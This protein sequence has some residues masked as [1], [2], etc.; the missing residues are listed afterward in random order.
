MLSIC[1]ALWSSI[2]K[3]HGDVSSSAP[4]H[5]SRHE[6]EHGSARMMPCERDIQQCH[7]DQ[8]DGI[9]DVVCPVCSNPGGYYS[10]LW[11]HP[12]SDVRY[13]RHPMSGKEIPGTWHTVPVGKWNRQDWDRDEAECQQIQQEMISTPRPL[14]ML[15]PHAG[16]RFAGFVRESVFSR[17]RLNPSARPVRW[18]YYIA[19]LHLDDK[20]HAALYIVRQEDPTMPIPVSTPTMQVH[21][22]KKSLPDSI[23]REHSYTWVEPELRENFPGAKHCVLIPSH[24]GYTEELATWLAKSLY[25]SHHQNHVLIVFTADLTHNYKDQDLHLAWPQQLSKI[26]REEDLMDSLISPTRSLETFLSSARVTDAPWAMAILYRLIQLV[27]CHGQVVDYMDSKAVAYAREG[28]G[29]DERLHVADKLDFYTLTEWKREAKD[30]QKILRQQQNAQEEDRDAFVSYVGM[31]FQSSPSVPFPKTETFDDMYLLGCIRS[32]ILLIDSIKSFQDRNLDMERVIAHLVPKWSVWSHLTNGVFVG[33]EEWD[34]S[35]RRWVTNCS[36]GDYENETEGAAEKRSVAVGALRAAMKCPHDARFRWLRPLN[37]KKDIRYKVEVLAPRS[38]WKEFMARDAPTRFDM[39]HGREGL[40]LRLAS[41]RAATYLP[42]VAREWGSND[43]EAYMS[44]LSQKAGGDASD[45][46][47]PKARAWT[48]TSRT[49]FWN[50][51]I[52]KLEK[53]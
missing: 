50:P 42:V 39:A 12:L 20:N 7:E 48:Y 25:R 4:H 35:T 14:I 46:K 23:R 29:N 38:E 30:D 11:S 36:Y 43:I 2:E 49:I 47:D 37:Q 19:A 27:Q 28:G 32:V 13:C 40:Y 34:E 22:E 24:H 26:E 15:I 51:R 53:D 52:Q 44:H 6:E 21:A 9:Q 33:T 45:W 18:I 31:V 10:G 16:K 5:A 41:Y 8:A 1:I 3:E 17:I